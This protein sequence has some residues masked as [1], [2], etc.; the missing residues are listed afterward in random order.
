MGSEVYHRRPGDA[1]RDHSRSKLPR[2]QVPP[3]STLSLRF[4]FNVLNDP[5]GCRV[6]NRCK[7][8]QGQDSGG[9][10]QALQHC[11]RLHPRGR[12]TFFASDVESRILNRAFPRLLQAQIKKENV[13]CDLCWPDYCR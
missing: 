1:V 12:G 7:H 9:N 8:D 13:S 4:H 6:Q 10:T 3:V 2:H 11:E 5:Q